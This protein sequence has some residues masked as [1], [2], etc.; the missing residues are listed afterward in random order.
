MHRPHTFHPRRWIRF[1]LGLLATA[2]GCASLSP[3]PQGGR[4]SQKDYHLSYGLPFLDRKALRDPLSPAGKGG[5]LE[6]ISARIWIVS[7]NQRHELLGTNIPGLR[8]AI[9]DEKFAESAIR[10]PQLDL[11]GQ[12]LLREALER[13]DG[14]VLHL[15]DACDISNTVE[16]ALFAWDMRGARSGWLMAPGNHDGYFMGNT[17]RVA[18]SWVRKWDDTGE[19]YEQ[20]GIAVTSRAMQKN[21][22][23]G[24]Y[25]AAIILQD[26]AWSEPLARRLGADCT[27]IQE[28]WTK[29]RKESGAPTFVQYWQHLESLQ[30]AAYKAA[31]QE[32][33]H[34]LD[35]SDGLK[36]G[37]GV[38]LRRI[39]WAID[40]EAPWKSYLVQEIDIGV[41]SQ[42][43]ISMLVLDTAQYTYR[44]SAEYGAL[45]YLPSKTGMF[46]QQLA[47]TH[48]NILESQVASVDWMMDAMRAEQRRWV[49]AVHHPYEDLGRHSWPRFD[50]I[51]DAGGVPVTLSAH[52]HDGE[53]RW[54]HDGEHEGAWLELNV[55]SMLDAPVEYRD[56]QVQRVGGRLAVS[57]R[58]FV[59]ADLLHE[60]G[61]LADDTPGYRPSSGDPDNY[62]DY[63]LGWSISAEASELAV[64]R[65]LLAA[66]LRMFSLFKTQGPDARKT[67]WP[68][69]ADGTRLD[70]DAKVLGELERM[71]ALPEDDVNLGELTHLLYRLR[72]FDRTRSVAESDKNALR[73]YRLSQAIWAGQAELEVRGVDPYELDPDLSFILLPADAKSNKSR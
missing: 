8:M 70:N 51:R 25:L 61:L 23:I 59:M 27:A 7:D 21:D 18:D 44:P 29:L 38:T 66:Y 14:F 69:R 42:Q 58:R 47:G 53:F 43:P 46:T 17:S 5:A 20:D 12:E 6:D 10:P 67:I 1:C 57:S 4:W 71:A 22:Y 54:H 65:I 13:T 49:V 56:F 19:K 28:R 33:Q 16:F 40:V 62:M 64:K 31:V 30:A 37:A 73:A 60:A 52:T 34:R 68:A 39:A 3:G 2:M 35:L 24:Y 48:G 45:S 32:S 55:G 63:R 9:A 72:E 15:G 26:T 36:A 50:R 11:F 41:D